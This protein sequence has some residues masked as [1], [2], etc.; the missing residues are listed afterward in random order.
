MSQ[1]CVD[2][3][4]GKILAGWR[5]DISGLAP[6]MRGDYESHLEACARCR[7]RQQLHRVID[8]GLIALAS[9]SA[10]VF[11]LAF[12]VIRHFGP[13]FA[14]WLEIAALAGFA[15]SAVIWL[16]VAV[17][18]PAPVTMLDAAK[19]GARRVHDRLPEE[20]R[21]RLP[22]ELRTKITGT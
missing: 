4:V 6:E 17:A 8:V 14:F 22:E 2:P 15:L 5:Y 20:I 21:Q 7:G 16:A 9:I 3:I 12:G 11:L 13:P 10:G 1:Q 19:E 18:T